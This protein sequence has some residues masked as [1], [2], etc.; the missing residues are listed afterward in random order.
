MIQT[1]NH[2]GKTQRQEGA[3][4]KTD[5]LYYAAYLFNE[6]LEFRG[7]SIDPVKKNHAVFFF[8]SPETSR[9]NQ[10]QEAYRSSE[11][12]TNIRT[13]LDALVLLRG[14]LHT[15]LKHTTRTQTTVIK[16]KKT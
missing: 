5:N 4:I 6:G 1:D 14:I 2:Q 10:I 8:Y 12:M 9:E 7:V 13:Y 11:A 15:T 3:Q 16:T